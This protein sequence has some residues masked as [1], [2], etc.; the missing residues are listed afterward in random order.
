MRIYQIFSRAEALEH[1][2]DLKSE[3]RQLLKYEERILVKETDKGMALQGQI[4][5]LKSML[6][7]HYKA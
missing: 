3:V 7:E 1:Y 4:A 6:K 2:A 5:V